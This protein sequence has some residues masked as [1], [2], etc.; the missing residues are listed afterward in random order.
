MVNDPESIEALY[1][2]RHCDLY[3]VMYNPREIEE[4]AR[5]KKTVSRVL[6]IRKGIELA[7]AM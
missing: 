1:Y 3:C 4:R 7:R 2:P 6:F 5:R